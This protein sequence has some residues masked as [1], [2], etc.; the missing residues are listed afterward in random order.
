MQQHPLFNIY[1]RRYLSEVTG[2]STGYLCR[3]ATGGHPLSR[4]FI[5]RVCFR[6]NRPEEELFLPDAAET[7]SSRSEQ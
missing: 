5:D 3:M 1:K 7:H 4:S 2:Y 6:L